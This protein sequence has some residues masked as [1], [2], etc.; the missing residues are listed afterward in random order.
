MRGARLLA[1][2]LWLAGLAGPALAVPCGGEFET[3]LEAFKSEAAGKGISARA[4]RARAA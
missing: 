2:A 3:W 4:R 1:S